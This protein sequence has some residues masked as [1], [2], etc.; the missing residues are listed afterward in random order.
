MLLNTRPEIPPGAEEASTKGATTEE[1]SAEEATSEEASGKELGRRVRT[2][3]PE[4]SQYTCNTLLPQH[5][6]A[7][8]HCHLSTLLL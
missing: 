4:L 1:A 2:D 5:T 8:I 7:P 6:T 3:G